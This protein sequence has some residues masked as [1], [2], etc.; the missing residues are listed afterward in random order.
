MILTPNHAPVS[1]TCRVRD[2]DLANA[3]RPVGS[4]RCGGSVDVDRRTY[5]TASGCRQYGRTGNGGSPLPTADA[6]GGD[7]DHATDGPDGAA[8]VAGPGWTSYSCFSGTTTKVRL[9]R[10]QSRGRRRFHQHGT[11]QLAPHQCR[12]RRSSSRCAIPHFR[13]RRNP[14]KFAGDEAG[15]GDQGW[16]GHSDAHVLVPAASVFSRQRP[17]AVSSG[18]NTERNKVVELV[19]GCS[20]CHTSYIL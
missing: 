6:T 20:R 10:P 17:V 5:R 16:G 9:R 11:E 12:S 1:N 2:R 3:I 13:G 14:A 18:I 15:W 19:K 8:V 4:R 7:G